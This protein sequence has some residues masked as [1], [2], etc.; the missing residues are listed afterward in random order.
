M[1]QL[2]QDIASQ[3]NLLA[4]NAAIEAA[5]AGET[6]KGF[7]VVASE[8][9]ALAHQTAKAT[10]EI[11]GQIASVQT[12]TTHVVRA[13]Q[14]IGGT[15]GKI[16]NIATIIAGTV[17][18]QSNAT[19]EI[20]RSAMEVAEATEGVSANIAGVG[21]AAGATGAAATQVLASARQLGR[22]SETLRSSVADFLEKIRAA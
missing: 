2:V 12:V 3:T 20:A 7:V 14:C 13:I 6:G 9:K 4:L 8:V 22:Q 17:E 10:K 19:R 1:L 11:A 21:L 16:D 5:R 15:V 18:Q